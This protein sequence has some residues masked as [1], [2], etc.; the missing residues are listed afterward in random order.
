LRLIKSRELIPV[1]GLSRRRRHAA[2]AV[3]VSENI[4]V[5]MF[6]RRSVGCNVE[7]CHVF[8][9]HGGEWVSLGGCGGPVA[10]DAFDHRPAALRA[11]LSASLGMDARILAPEGAGGILDSRAQGWWQPRGRWINYGIVRV[12]ADVARLVVDGR[13][14]SVPWHG[15][16]VVAWPGRRAQELAILGQDGRGLG[17]VVLR[18]SP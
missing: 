7:E 18:P 1:T 14:I 2:M 15:R 16:C 9:R 5:T 4:A 12:N 17:Q 11:G 8:A 6:V 13:V 10:D 3:D